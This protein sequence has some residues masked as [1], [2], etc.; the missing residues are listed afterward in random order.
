MIVTNIKKF[1]LSCVEFCPWVYFAYIYVS[2]ILAP[3]Q[4]A[5]WDIWCWIQNPVA[6]NTFV[7]W[8]LS[9]WNF[10]L[11]RDFLKIQETIPRTIGLACL[12]LFKRIFSD[13]NNIFLWH[14]WEDINKESLFPKFQLIPILGFQV[15]HGYVF[16]IVPIDYCVEKKSRVWD[17]LWKLLSFHTEMIS[18]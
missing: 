10:E 14:E 17:F 13:S 18:A 11:Y 8:W 6:C 7:C 12:Y 4:S 16:F 3:K 9:V 1:H 15:M 5:L 2:C